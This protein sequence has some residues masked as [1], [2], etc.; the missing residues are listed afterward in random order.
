M[1]HCSLAY[2]S[3]QECFLFYYLADSPTAT[4]P[5]NPSSLF[6]WSETSLSK[7]CSD[8]ATRTAAVAAPVTFAAVRIISTTLEIGTRSTMI[9]TGSP[10]AVN[11]AVVVTVEVPGTPTVPMETISVNTIRNTYWTGT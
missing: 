11:S 4:A 6:P 8:F 5:L 1:D 3:R 9:S 10:A 2:D 7:S